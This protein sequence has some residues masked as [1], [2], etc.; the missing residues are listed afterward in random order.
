MLPIDV[1]VGVL[2]SRYERSTDD[3][4]QLIMD[5]RLITP[6]FLVCRPNIARFLPRDASAQRGYEDWMSSV[7]PSVRP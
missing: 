6:V 2:K 5:H 1:V 4:R 3:E 7:R